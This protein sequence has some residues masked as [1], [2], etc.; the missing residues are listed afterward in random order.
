[1]IPASVARPAR[2]RR[3]QLGVEP[4]GPGDGALLRLDHGEAAELAPGAGHHS[5]LERSRERRVLL[6]QLLVEKSVDVVLGHAAQDEVLVGP[7]TYG[8]VTVGRRQ[9]SGLHQFDPDIRPTGTEHPT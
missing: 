6:E 3:R 1:M 7:Q 9:S 2:R 4:A 8:A 5:P